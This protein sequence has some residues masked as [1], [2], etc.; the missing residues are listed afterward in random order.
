M[1]KTKDQSCN[2]HFGIGI[3]IHNHG[4]RSFIISD[5]LGSDVKQMVK[6]VP[7]SC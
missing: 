1:A 6:N 2:L 7:L 3:Y 4:E 5:S